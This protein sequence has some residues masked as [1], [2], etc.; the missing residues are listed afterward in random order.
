MYILCLPHPGISRAGVHDENARRSGLSLT[1]FKAGGIG[2][3][4]VV[5]G[6]WD[7]P[8]GAIIHP[9]NLDSGVKRWCTGPR[10]SP[11][12]TAAL[13]RPS[14]SGEDVG[15]DRVSCAIRFWLLEGS[16]QDIYSWVRVGYPR[17]NHLRRLSG[18][19]AGREWCRTKVSIE[20]GAPDP[21]LGHLFLMS[22]LGLDDRRQPV[23]IRKR[24]EVAAKAAPQHGIIWGTPRA[25]MAGPLVAS[26]SHRVP[27]VG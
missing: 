23:A 9:T 17:V 14:E 20:W 11:M 27:K 13:S 6:S 21:W 5:W 24:L 1:R 3:W 4:R 12:G 16:V 19:R 22:V 2:T 15:C 25:Y 26:R 18:N 7:L 10:L 8:K